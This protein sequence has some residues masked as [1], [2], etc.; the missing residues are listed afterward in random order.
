MSHDSEKL[1]SLASRFERIAVTYKE[2]PEI[3][4]QWEIVYFADQDEAEEGS[5]EK[6]GNSGITKAL[7]K[8]WL[9]SSGGGIWEDQAGCQFTEN[10]VD[11][12]EKGKAR[13]ET[14]KRL[15]KKEREDRW[16]AASK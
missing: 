2:T 6:F 10:E 5:K 4:K 1:L 8:G 9:I 14:V 13:P 12:I 3:I 15:R 7:G 16:K 11:L